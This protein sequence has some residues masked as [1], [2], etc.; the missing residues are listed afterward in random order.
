M[1]LETWVDRT[2]RPAEFGQNDTRELGIAIADWT[3]VDAPPP[4]AAVI[5]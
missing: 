1:M 4:G 5:E 3:F 2:W